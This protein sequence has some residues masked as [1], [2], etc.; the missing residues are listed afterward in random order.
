MLTI[1]NYKIINLKIKK[2]F[3]K[4]FTGT[5]SVKKKVVGTELVHPEKYFLVSMENVYKTKEIRV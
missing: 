5:E 2:N 1:K 3:F 4:I